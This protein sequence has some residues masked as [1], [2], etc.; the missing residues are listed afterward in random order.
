MLNGIGQVNVKN[1]LK[2]HWNINFR[3]IINT[4]QPE[5]GYYGSIR[6]D[7]SDTGIGAVIL[8]K[9]KDEKNEGYS[10]CI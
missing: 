7:V 8:H 3:F 1:P 6:S 9:F 2:N 4:L 5:T 10:A